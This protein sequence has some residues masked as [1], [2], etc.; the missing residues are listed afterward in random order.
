MAT[1]E[2]KNLAKALPGWKVIER[3]FP[4]VAVVSTQAGAGGVE[5]LV[6]PDG[7]NEP[8]ATEFN[9]LRLQLAQEILANRYREERLLAF[10][11]RA[12]GDQLDAIIKG[13]KSASN[14]GIDLDQDAIDLIQWSDDIK[15]AHPKPSTLDGGDA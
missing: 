13:L 14:G 5:E 6:W 15:A 12:V 4:G 7:A 3:F 2:A 1:T 8:T 9:A 10:Q 11:E